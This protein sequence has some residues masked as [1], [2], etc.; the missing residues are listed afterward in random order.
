[1]ILQHDMKFDDYVAIVRRR[2]WYL[3]FPAIVFS[4]GAYVLSIYLPTKYKSETVVLVQEQRISEDIVRSVVN[5]G[6]NERLATMQEQILSRTRLQQ[7]IEKLGLFKEE[8]GKKSPEDLV[9]QL[10]ASIVISPV[11]PMAETHAD[12]LPGFTINVTA[13]KPALAQQICTEITSLFLQQNV[14][15]RAQSAEDTTQ[16]IGTQLADAKAKLDEQDAKLAEFQRKY[17]GSL[18]DQAQTNFSW[19]SSLSSQLDSVNQAIDR[20]HQDQVYLQTALGQQITAA[21]L[22][23]AGTNPDTLGRQLAVM[24]EQLATLRARYTDEHPDVVKLKLDIAHLQQRMQN[25]PA[26]D[27][28]KPAPVGADGAVIET[29]QIQQ[30]HAQIHQLDVSIHEKTV[31]QARIQQKIVQLQ[32]KLELSPSVEQ[33][34]K[35]LTR[36][37]QT[38]LGI[39]TDLLKKQSV[40][41]MSTDLEKRQEGEQFRVLDPPSLPQKPSF[42]NRKA[43]AVAGLMG[44]LGL[45]GVIGFLLELKD[46]S[47]RTEREVEMVLKLPTLATIPMVPVQA[48]SGLNNKFMNANLKRG[49]EPLGLD[50][51]A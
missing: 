29:P 10:R 28:L 4:V 22:G 19:L 23:Q 8:I 26:T 11:R 21:K 30:L 34:Y 14:V 6:L 39:Y 48:P 13:S 40:S 43:F 12:G 32:A 9:A 17:Q 33:E 35:A 24:Q 15:L 45:G 42:P 41:E 44:G 47:L 16:F 1:M 18:P 50:A 27:T 38:A 36:D 46:T 51:G 5:G 20:A 2:V 49:R 7:I 37:Y 31:E 25:Q 3:V